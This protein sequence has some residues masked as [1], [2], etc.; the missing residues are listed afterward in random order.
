MHTRNF[1]INFT[2]L[3]VVYYSWCLIGLMVAHCV[4]NMG[5]CTMRLEI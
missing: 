3:C 5:V 2:G 1:D 4:P